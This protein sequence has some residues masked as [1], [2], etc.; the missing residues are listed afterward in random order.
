MTPVAAL[1]Q[2]GSRP[3]RADERVVITDYRTVDAVAADEAL[4]YAVTRGG[5]C[6]YDHR[7]RRWEPPVSEPE[8][9]GWGT[10]RDAAV[11][12]TDGSLWLGTD[13]GLVNY[14]PRVD[15]LEQTVVAGG[16]ATLWL[17]RRD[18]VASIYFRGISGWQ[19][20]PRGGAIP[21]P[22]NPSAPDRTSLA[23]A[24]SRMRSLFTRYPSLTT[25]SARLLTDDRMRTYRFTSA[26][27]VPA[28]EAVFL[29]TDGMGLVKFDITTGD[30]ETLAFGLLAS[31]TTAVEPVEG[32]VW[33]GGSDDRSWSSLSF[34]SSDLQHYEYVEGPPVTGLAGTVVNDLLAI[35]S[36]LWL[37]TDAGVTV[38]TDGRQSRKIT[39]ADGLP[40]GQALALAAS[41]DGVVVGTERGLTRITDSSVER[42]GE[43]LVARVN[44]L[45][46]LGDSVWVA[47][48]V[49]LGW[50]LSGSD[51]VLEIPGAEGVPELN[52]DIVAVTVAGEVLAAATRRR[53]I[54][55]MPSSG[56][57]WVVERPVAGE[58]GEITALA[59]D[60]GGI[61][62]GGAGGFA[63][64]RFGS[65]QFT[66]FAAPGDVPGPV[67][68][69]AADERFLW[70]ATEGGLVRFDIDRVRGER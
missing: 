60:A 16:V 41:P 66:F 27:E 19:Q 9:G 70:V 28:A 49:G 1:G 45:A 38:L 4:V 23:P 68:D 37:A 8:R 56:P 69:L 40:A 47:S 12:P 35:G 2:R 44:G 14:Q 48:S 65:R 18:P 46:A 10:V 63:Q 15:R 34:V 30:F 53:V 6:V 55:R 22:A 50:S 64:Y 29:G 21:I 52:E 26:A 58:L 54:W 13:Q 57:R 67:W 32:G 24:A 33:V 61:W 51:R 17:D 5:I 36:E 7:F 11:D 20:L 43:A 62:I 59:A 31:A 3:W 25:L 42:L 39:S